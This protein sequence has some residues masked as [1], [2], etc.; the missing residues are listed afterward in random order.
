MRW[1]FLC[2][3][4]ASRGCEMSKRMTPIA[5]CVL[6]LAGCTPTP[7]PITA[8]PPVVPYTAEQQTRA[9]D[10][11]DAL[12]ADAALREMMADY[13]RVRNQLRVCAE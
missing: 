2:T 4:F 6:S 9:A 10:E 7:P 1:I 5:L 8:C 12:P 13:A 3:M 11:L